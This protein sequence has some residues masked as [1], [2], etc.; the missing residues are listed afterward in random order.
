MV[1]GTDNGRWIPELLNDTG[2]GERHVVVTQNGL[3]D[4]TYLDYLRLQY[5]DRLSNLTDEDSK[6]AFNDFV[7]DAQRRV[8]HDQQFPDEPKQVQPGEN[9]KVVDG[10]V[11]VNGIRAVMAVNE[12]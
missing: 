4:G 10:K 6:R 9:I 11:Q 8:D 5:D 2:D 7:A 1:G 3:A 12:N